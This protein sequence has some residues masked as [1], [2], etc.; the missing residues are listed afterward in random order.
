LV[1]TEP[2]NF[3]VPNRVELLG[4]LQELIPTCREMFADPP[5]TEIRTQTVLKTSK[6]GAIP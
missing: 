6:S 2:D 1:V 3:Q 5:V 4:R